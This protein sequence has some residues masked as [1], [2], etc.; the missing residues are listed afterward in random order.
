MTAKNSSGALTYPCS[1]RGLSQPHPSIILTLVPGLL[2]FG[3]TIYIMYM[4][5]QNINYSYDNASS[6]NIQHPMHV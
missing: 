1:L 3:C 6:K 4:S 2:K 5:L